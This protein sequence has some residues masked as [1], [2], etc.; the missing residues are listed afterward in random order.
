M[1]TMNYSTLIFDAF[2][3][4]IHINES[5][6]PTHRPDGKPVATTAH[7]AYASGHFEDALGSFRSA[8]A[9]SARLVHARASAPCLC[10]VADR[11]LTN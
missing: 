4:V 9:R 10:T 3:T 8:A 11:A 2:D 1:R 7:A 6:L 5:K